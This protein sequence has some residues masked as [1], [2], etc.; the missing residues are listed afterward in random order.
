[1]I[2]SDHPSLTTLIRHLRVSCI[3]C[4]ANGDVNRSDHATI[5]SR[6]EPP[7][8]RDNVDTGNQLL[9]R[10]GKSWCQSSFAW[11]R[12]GNSMTVILQQGEARG[13]I[14]TRRGGSG[15]ADRMMVPATSYD[16]CMWGLFLEPPGQGKSPR[17]Q[18]HLKDTWVCRSKW[19][20]ILKCKLRV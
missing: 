4:H 5:I 1:V 6:D 11:R 7:W 9:R 19:L 2:P 16:S 8:W 10:L 13:F 14:G 12:E 3:K 15:E 20:V 18:R 17:T